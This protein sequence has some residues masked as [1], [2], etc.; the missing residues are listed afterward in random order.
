MQFNASYIPYSKTNAFSKLVI[1]YLE[2]DTALQ[3]FYKY[4]PHKEGIEQAIKDRKNNPTDRLLLVNHFSKTYEGLIAS[5]A[6][7]FN[8]DSLV[9]ENTFTICTAHQPNIFTGHLYFIYKIMH[10]IKLADELN[11]EYKD[12]HFVP[13]Y[14]MGSEDADLEEL[15]EIEISG[16]KYTWNTKQTGAVG[17]MKIDKPFL[18]LIDELEAQL[19]VETHGDEIIELVKK[20]YREGET[21]ESSTF[22][23]VHALFQQYGLLILLPD[24]AALKKSFAPIMRKELE[25]QFSADAVAETIKHFPA[26]YKVQAAGRELNLFYL[27]DNIRERIEATKNGFAIANTSLHFS[28][29]ELLSELDN[30]PE[31]FSPNVILRPVFQEFILP[32]IVFIGGGGELA[33]WLELEKVFEVANVFFPMLVLRNSFMLLQKKQLKL[34]QKHQLN[35]V[36][37]FMPVNDLFKSIVEKLSSTRLHLDEEKKSLSNLYEQIAEAAAKVDKSLLLHSENLKV[38]TIK[39]L[40]QLEQKMLRAEKKKFEATERQIN[41]IKSG[42]FPGGTLQ[43]RKDNLLYWYAIWGTDFIK[44]LY[45]N[46]KGLQQEF[47][48]IEEA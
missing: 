18:Q 27:N 33:Y 8:I 10:A 40:E 5:P 6:V 19:K 37:F 14:Y 42:L 4:I 45:E 23:F 39:R 34:M 3:P 38:K 20:Y 29:V 21:I 25:Q 7:K 22:Q 15:G 2:N 32:N 12:I 13:V 11:A 47:Y 35:P 43:E 31:R 26:T 44:M 9:Q 30:H 48:V 1:D 16:K 17:R 24:D 36:D 46:S 41:K 28:P